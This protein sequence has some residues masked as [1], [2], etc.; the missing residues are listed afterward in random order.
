ML[1]TI[2]G[3][4]QITSSQSPIETLK[5]EKWKTTWLLLV[6]GLALVVFFPVLSLFFVTF[7]ENIATIAGITQNFTWDKFQ[8]LYTVEN[9]FQN[10]FYFKLISKEFSWYNLSPKGYH[11]ISLFFHLINSGLAFYSVWL[12]TKRNILA[13]VAAG[14]FAIHPTRSEAVAAILGQGELLMTFFALLST[15]SY[16]RYHDR[17]KEI[18][19]PSF[20]NL[21]SPENT[22]YLYFSLL[23]YVFA[24]LFKFTALLLP[25]VFILIDQVL[26]RQ[27]QIKKWT[28]KIGFFLLMLIGLGVMANLQIEPSSKNYF[29]VPDYN[30]FDRLILVIYTTGIYLKNLLIPYN[31]SPFYPYPAKTGFILHWSCYLVSAMTVG[32]GFVIWKLKNHIWLK[33]GVLFFLVQIALFSNILHLG[34]RTFANDENIYFASLGIFIAIGYGVDYILATKPKYHIQFLGVFGAAIL[35]FLV[36]SYFT[37]KAYTNG[38]TLWT[39]MVETNPRNYYVRMKRGEIRML[40]ENNYREG[41]MDL[42]IALE[43]MPD[44]ADVWVSKGVMHLHIGDYIVADSL[45]TQALKRNPE[46]YMAYFHRAHTHKGYERYSEALADYDKSI[47]FNPNYA[48]AYLNRGGV[49]QTVKDFQGA[50]KDYERAIKLDPNYGEA[51]LNRGNVYFLA[52]AYTMAIKDYD[53]A[54]VILPR[55]TDAFFY[56]GLTR[57]QLGD[58]QGA[59]MDLDAAKNLGKK[60]AEQVIKDICK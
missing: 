7:D 19:K 3:N 13:L 52:Q 12:L 32:L 29:G 24:I 1:K 18:T 30:I 26:N 47:R 23:F 4:T 27:Q 53:K 56:R 22:K 60:E 39:R 51:Y 59:C 48:P 46:H 33:F 17:H 25:F 57:S 8:K 54:L 15:I 42:N 21:N 45:F 31:I 43:E 50:L 14:L 20:N 5:A 34:G 36:M 6:M 10:Y 49:K 16:L 28:E 40:D 11:T 55:S 41:M 9:N 44:D 35:G 2:L 58:K 37:T 38:M